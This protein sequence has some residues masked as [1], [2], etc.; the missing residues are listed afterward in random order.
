MLL[1]ALGP[2]R[3]SEAALPREASAGSEAEWRM[4]VGSEAER[5]GGKGHGDEEGRWSVE[6]PA[7]IL[8]E[9]SMKGALHAP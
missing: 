4:V 8:L 2:C 7:A 1:V 5:F 3:L 9:L 6:G